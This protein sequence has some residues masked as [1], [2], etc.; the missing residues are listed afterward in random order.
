M[1]NPTTLTAIVEKNTTMPASFAAGVNRLLEYTVHCIATNPIP[2]TSVTCNGITRTPFA[3]DTVTQSRVTSTMFLFFES[4]L[5]T[6]V[7]QAVTINGATA[8]TIKSTVK[9]LQD[10]EQVTPTNKVS[11]RGTG[12]GNLNLSLVRSS[13]SLTTLYSLS[14]NVNYTATLANPSGSGMIQVGG[15]AALTHGSMADS[16]GTVVATSSTQSGSQQTAMAMNYKYAP[17]PP[18]KVG[19]TGFVFNLVGAGFSTAPTSVSCAYGAGLAKNLT[20]SLT[21]ATT[22]A[23]TTTL[24]DRAEGVDYPAVGDTLTF[25]ITN[26]TTTFVTNRTLAVKTGE[27]AKTFTGPNYWQDTYLAYR[28]DQDGFNAEGAEFIFTTSGFSPSDFALRA[29]SG[30]SSTSGGVV[31]GWF[32]PATGT[33]AG[34]VYYYQFTINDAGQIVS[35]VTSRQPIL[36]IGFGIGI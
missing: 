33:G 31:T 4:E 22:S 12:G 3:G 25:T 9:L 36:G 17:S 27:T 16:A 35:V 24:E 10:V 23:A 1:P 2:P 29:D 6:I 28:W 14:Q 32:R 5:A 19:E 8:T 20:C 18:I 11:V 34:N 30:F 7:N 21:A 15:V 26:G 13:D